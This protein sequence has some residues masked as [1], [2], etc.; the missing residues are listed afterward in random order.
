MKPAPAMLFDAAD[1]PAVEVM[2]ESHTSHGDV[3][4]LLKWTGSKRSQAA[5]IAAFAPEHRRYYEPFLGGGAL[6]Y[7]LGRDGSVGGD[8]YSPLVEFWRMVR[9]DSNRLIDDY[10]K[11]WAA[12]QLTFLP[13]TTWFA[14]ALTLCVVQK[15]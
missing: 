14:S 10:A 12:L 7:M 5:R 3:P 2:K 6:L 9:D 13:T 11:Q 4:S 1:L 15:I 8:I